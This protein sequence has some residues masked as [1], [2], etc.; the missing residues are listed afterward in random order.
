MIRKQLP[1]FAVGLLAA[2]CSAQ[3]PTAQISEA[4]RRVVEPPLRTHLPD[5]PVIVPMVGSRTLP[6]VE[7]RINGQGPYRFLLDSAANVTLLQ[8]RIADKLKLPILRP[9]Q[10]SRLCAVRTIQIGEAVFDDLIVGAR[11]WNEEIDGVIGF[12]LF[13]ECLLTMD[14]PRQRILLTRGELPAENGKDI[15]R[16]GLDNRC[17][18]MQVRIGNE[19]TWLLV[20]TG[21]VPGLVITDKCAQKL[22]FVNGLTA[23]PKLSTFEASASRSRIGRLSGSVWLGVHEVVNPKVYVWNDDVPVIGSGLLSD[24]VLTFDQKNQRLRLSV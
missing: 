17:P 19:V 4:R 3:E 18:T 6:L 7:V 16:Y 12:N 24:F 11:T 1:F 10:E 22:I 5:A 8:T 14:F 20:D 13:A 23:G 21:A 2:V 9:G 15:I